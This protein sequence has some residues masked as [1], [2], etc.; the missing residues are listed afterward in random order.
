[1]RR[2][3][4]AREDRDVSQETAHVPHRGSTPPSR[5]AVVT[6]GNRGIGLEVGTLFHD[7]V[8]VAW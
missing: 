4:A 7:R 2:S 6:G 1:M 5:T 8:P 3:A